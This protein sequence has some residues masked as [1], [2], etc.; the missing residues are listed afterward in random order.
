M[1]RDVTAPEQ[2]GDA[3]TPRPPAT[4]P[5]SFDVDAKEAQR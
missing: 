1:N 5:P 4:P 2:A 3:Q